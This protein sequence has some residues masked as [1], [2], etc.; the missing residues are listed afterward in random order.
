MNRAGG[1]IRVCVYVRA[2]DTSRTRSLSCVWLFLYKRILHNFTRRNDVSFL[3]DYS[4]L[5]ASRFFTR[6]MIFHPRH[7]FF[8]RVMTFSSASGFFGN[9]STPQSALS[10][11]PI[12]SLYNNWK[13]IGLN[14][15]T[16]KWMELLSA[17][18]CTRTLISM[19][20]ICV[21]LHSCFVK[22]SWIYIWFAFLRKPNLLIY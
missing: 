1:K 12:Y 22:R 3:F 20:C 13:V 16:P 18:L 8:I 6:V 4:N 17:Y 2:K 21:S 7:G 9:R 11:V 14:C 19:H 5:S 10:A 15:E